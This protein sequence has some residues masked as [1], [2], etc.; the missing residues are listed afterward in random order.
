MER[1]VNM[2][3]DK[4]LLMVTVSGADR[5]GITARFTRVLLNHAVE[6]V[7][8]E[9]ASLQNLLGLYFLLDLSQSSESKDSVIKDLLF[10][11]SQLG[12]TLNFRLFSEAEVQAVNQRN[13]Y[14]LTHFG[15]TRAIAEFSQILAEENVN[16]ETIS[17]LTHHG[18]R[19]LE[20]V[21][22]AQGSRGLGRF[23]QRIMFKSRELNVDMAI[24]KMEAYRKNKRMI[25]F[26]MDSTL[27]DMEIIDEMARRAGVHREV[28]RITEKAMRGD[29]DFEEALIQRVALLKGMTVKSLMEI[30]HNIPLSEGAEELVVT[31]KWLGFKVGVVTGGFDFF[32]EHLKQRLGLDFAHSNCLEIRNGA[33]T[34][35]VSG[36]IIDAAGKARIVNQFSCDLGIPLDQIVVVGD[37]ANDA[38]MIGQA[39]LGIA[40]NA[41]KRLDSV[42]NV[43]LGKARLT[44]LYHLLGI[45]EEDIAAA[46]S[47]RVPE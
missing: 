40:Y 39:G 42:A 14:V 30:R 12:V 38:L 15:G 24:Q 35:R 36:Q 34:G 2:L 25:F 21:I 46:M 8:I 44:H 4:N 20:M 43:T 9:Q 29:Y 16:I 33:L 7:D 45:T 13:L 31:L 32:A 23:K 19:S 27:V 18:T 41:K 28:A 3:D 47:C 6:V 37:G 22:D 10:E 11:A 26:D 17:S 5:P 1:R